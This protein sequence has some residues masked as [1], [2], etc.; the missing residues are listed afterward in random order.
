MGLFR[1]VFL[2][3][4]FAIGCGLRYLTHRDSTTYKD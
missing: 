2:C 4:G 1:L 3:L